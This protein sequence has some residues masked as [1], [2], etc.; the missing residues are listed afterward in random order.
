MHDPLL[1]AA[2]VAG[3]LLLLAGAIFAAEIGRKVA[4]DAMD[5]DGGKGK[6]QGRRHDDLPSLRD[7]DAKVQDI[8]NVDDFAPLELGVGAAAGA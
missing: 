8:I 2:I 4:N 1:P 7:Y 5:V 6:N 3:W